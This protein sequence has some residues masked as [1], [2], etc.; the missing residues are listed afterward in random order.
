MRRA[1]TWRRGD[2]EKTKQGCS[3]AF[4]SAPR[5]LRVGVFSLLLAAP[6]IGPAATLRIDVADERRAPVWTRLEVRNPVGEMF[7]P[8]VC[9]HETMTKARGGKPYYLRSFIVH[10]GADLEVPAGRYTVIAEH[11]LEYERIERQ[12]RVVEDA[13]ARVAIQLRPWI[14]MREKGWWSGD[15]HVHRPL[16]DA[17]GIAQA[18]DLNFTVLVNRGKQDLF[19]ADHWPTQEAVEAAP[20]YWISLRNAEDE[21]RGGSWILNSLR[22]PLQ[23]GPESGWYPMGL[24]YVEQARAQP[25]AG[26]VL[27]WFDI[28][29]PFWWE[30]PVMMALATPDSLDILHN[31]FMQ[32]GIDDSEY[33]GRPRDRREY[34]GW[35]GFVDYS[36]DL[37]YRYLNLGFRVPPSAGTGTGVMPRSAGYDRVYAQIDRPFTVEKWYAAIR[38]GRS[39][40]TNGPMLF[41]DVERRR[42]M[43]AIA[44]RAVAREPIDRIELVADGKVVQKAAAPGEARLAM[45]ARFEIDARRYGWCAVRC[46]LKTPDNIRLAHSTPIYLDGH[47]DS[48]ADAAYFVDWIDDLIARTMREAARFRNADERNEVVSKYRQARAIYQAKE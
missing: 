39:F 10:G 43:A 38:A 36:M 3:S 18:E 48:R 26:G 23:L 14:R 46:F 8:A 21:R 24:R 30:V 29:M 12:V 19:R 7:Q 27:P 32:Y 47:P 15:V 44:V 4:F 9:I 16:A 6:A 37:Y 13:P 33:W 34:P 40:V 11:G 28:D 5:R 2:A 42:G 1:L 45:S 17:P 25:E 31:Q 35:Q 20:G 22:S 41:T